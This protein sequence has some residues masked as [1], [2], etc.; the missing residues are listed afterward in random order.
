MRKLIFALVLLLALPIG[1]V[2]DIDFA[3]GIERHSTGRFSFPIPTT[4]TM[5]E[6]D[7]VYLYHSPEKPDLRD[8]FLA[9]NEEYYEGIEK[10]YTLGMIY[11]LSLDS[12]LEAYGY[13]KYES[14]YINIGLNQSLLASFSP[15][16]SIKSVLV[17][18]YNAGTLFTAMISSVGYS[19]EELKEFILAFSE[20]LSY[21]DT[22]DLS[23][24][25]YGR[26]KKYVNIRSLPN[27]KSARV[28]SVDAGTRLTVIYPYYT[29]KWHQI[30]YNDK[31]CY[32]SANYIE[33]E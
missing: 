25:T 9:V 20:N 18:C 24:S 19:F 4:W 28:G 29:E 10:E 23:K 6:K 21:N 2:A 27:S 32:V 14:E 1:V 12:L 8:V 7:G 3:N 16:G 17:K 26:V 15:A 30:I 5:E 31:I 33:L 22:L 13:P 11:S